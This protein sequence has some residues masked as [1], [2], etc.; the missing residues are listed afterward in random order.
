MTDFNDRYA[1]LAHALQTGV[2]HTIELDEKDVK[3]GKISWTQPGHS[4]KMLRTGVNMAMIETGAIV[5]ILIE[6]DVFTL[7]E[8]QAHLARMM[9]EEIAR[10][11]ADLSQRMGVKVSLA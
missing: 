2:A 6:K 5:R 9:E 4:Q 3:S 10:Y 1:A 11:E 8:Y 7:E